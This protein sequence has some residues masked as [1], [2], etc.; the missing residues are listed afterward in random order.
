MAERSLNKLNSKRHLFYN[1]W[2]N[3]VMDSHE[4]CVTSEPALQNMQESPVWS[5]KISPSTITPESRVHKQ[6]EVIKK[7]T[8]VTTKR[9]SLNKRFNEQN[10]G[11]ACAL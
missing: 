6:E 5:R 2:K 3:E 11:S 9:A 7:M 10:N 8:T 1:N 4:F